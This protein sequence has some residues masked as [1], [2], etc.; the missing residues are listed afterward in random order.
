MAGP[1]VGWNAARRSLAS[2]SAE[3]CRG[4]GFGNEKL[5]TASFEDRTPQT[6]LLLPETPGVVHE[7]ISPVTVGRAYGLRV[8]AILHDLIPVKLASH[9]KA[10]V[11]AVYAGYFRMLA[12]ADL[13]ITTT[14]LVAADFRGFLQAEGLAPPPIVVVPLGGDFAGMDRPLA[15]PQMPP[16]SPFS[17]LMVGTWEARKNHIRVLN[18]LGEV[19]ARSSRA[20]TLTIVGRRGHDA[21]YDQ[22]VLACLAGHTGVTVKPWVSDREL[23]TLYGTHRASVYASYEEGFGLPVVESLWMGVPCLCH[24]GSAMQ[25]V[26]VGG[27]TLMTDMLDEAAIANSLQQIVAQDGLLEQLEFEAAKRPIQTWQDSACRLGQALSRGTG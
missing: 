9:Y 16:G 17:L 4:L 10:D 5:P 7:G 24:A 21:A 12:E 8:A 27:G 22:T 25:A 11:T 19:R 15:R 2:L 3:E 14:E 20:I 6:W 23:A 18:A 1:P 13:V 26:A